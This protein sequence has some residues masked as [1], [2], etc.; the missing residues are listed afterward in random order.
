MAGP[1]LV[2]LGKITITAAGTTV[3]LSVNCGAQAGSV[4]TGLPGFAFR[5]IVL[6]GD[7]ANTG[8]VFLL[9]NGKTVSSNPDQIIAV[10]G[11]SAIVPIPHGVLA[12]SGL[13]PENFCLDTD[14]NSQIVYG[15]G[16][17]G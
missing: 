11:P 10:I 16:I 14:T 4:T 9:P 15:Y 6:M 7:K 8:Q 5:G 3:K 1:N 13:L 2:P 17:L 12:A